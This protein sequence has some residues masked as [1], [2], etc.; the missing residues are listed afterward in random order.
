MTTTSAEAQAIAERYMALAARLEQEEAQFGTNDDY[1]TG[2]I[3]I[4][5]KRFARTVAKPYV[6]PTYYT[7]V[8]RKYSD[9]RWTMTGRN[10]QPVMYFSEIVAELQRDADD[11]IVE[12][13]TETEELA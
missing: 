12:I 11:L 13:V 4:V 7:Y 6:N 9:N 5:R 8:V 3:L 2:V 1:E 10:G